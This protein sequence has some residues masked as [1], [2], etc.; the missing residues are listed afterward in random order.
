MQ[1]SPAILQSECKTGCTPLQPYNESLVS[2]NTAKQARG[3]SKHS[4]L[5]ATTTACVVPLLTAHARACTLAET[6]PKS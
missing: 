6:E 2:V 1:A 5:L 4:H 3:I